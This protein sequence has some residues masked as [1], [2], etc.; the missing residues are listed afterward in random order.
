MKLV[1]EGYLGGV[2]P[3][4]SAEIPVVERTVLVSGPSGAGKGTVLNRVLANYPDQYQWSVSCTTR[5]PRPGE[6]DG[7][8]YF[9]LSEE[10]FKARADAGYF[11]E[12]QS[13]FGKSYGTPRVDQ[14]EVEPGKVLIVELETQGA[15]NMIRQ[16]PSVKRVFILPPSMAVL[17][18]R[19]INRSKGAM[20]LEE[21]LER[22]A[23]IPSEIEA[24]ARLGYHFVL[25]DE[26]EH[27]VAS[28]LAAAQGVYF[29]N[30]C[31]NDSSMVPK[32]AVDVFSTLDV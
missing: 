19:L 17:R 21:I 29:A 25:N 3:S 27:A 26:V 2:E 12:W 11:S 10:E 32:L 31:E 23:K 14:V 7:R 18:E 4:D 6:V 24:A 30:W 15:E 5:D 8:E 9:F 20:P 13:F 16:F 28:V 1:A 22:N